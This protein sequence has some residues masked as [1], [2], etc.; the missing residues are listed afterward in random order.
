MSLKHK[1]IRLVKT[2]ADLTRQRSTLPAEASTI[3]PERL[4]FSV[5]NG[6]R[7]VPLGIATRTK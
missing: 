2:T 6:K 3:D 5:R 4:N 1:K 7:C